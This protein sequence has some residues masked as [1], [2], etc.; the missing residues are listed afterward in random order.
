VLH[1]LG[2]ASVASISSFDGRGGVP[3]AAVSND[4]SLPLEGVS[5]ASNSRRFIC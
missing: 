4:N 3:S 2:A 5:L 1:Q